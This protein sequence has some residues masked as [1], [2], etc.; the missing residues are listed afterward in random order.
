MMDNIKYYKIILGLGVIIVVLPLL[1]YAQDETELFQ[2]GNQLYRAGEY[3][4]ALDSYLEIYKSGYESGPLYYNIGN[5]YYKCNETGKAILY[6]ERARKLMP[7]DEELE[8]N[9]KL[10]NLSVVD[11]IEPL[12]TFFLFRIVN[13]FI[14]LIP[15][16]ILLW[17][18]AA[19]YLFFIT[20][21]MIRILSRNEFLRRICFRISIFCL[22]FFI[23][24]GFSLFTQITEKTQQEEAVIM[25]EEIHVKGAPSEG[26]TTLFTL[27]EGTKVHIEKTSGDW[28][29]VLLADGK[30]GWVKREILEKI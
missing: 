22:V 12:P 18:V 30:V 6:Y 27:H 7:G 21:L 4:N 5:C 19:L 3:E 10:A 2:Q 1:L 15:K 29:E 24:F 23:I 16:S 17:I 25:A 8:F 28:F 13:G 20:F 14:Y 26:A 11:K 9:L